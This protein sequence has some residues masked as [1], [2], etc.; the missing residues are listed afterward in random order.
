MSPAHPS[1]DETAKAEEKARKQDPHG[2]GPTGQ[3]AEEQPKARPTSDREK[4]ETA[5]SQQ[6]G[7]G[8][9]SKR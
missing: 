6:K 3:V 2:T 9:A 5:V 4:T 7:P 8:D 1:P